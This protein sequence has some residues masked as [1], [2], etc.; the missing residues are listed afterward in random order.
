MNYSSPIYEDIKTNIK[1]TDKKIFIA[2]YANYGNIGDVA[3][4]IAQEAILKDLFP[5]RKIVKIPMFNLLD[6]IV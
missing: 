2:M 1:K 3:I 4:T 6:Y 5:D